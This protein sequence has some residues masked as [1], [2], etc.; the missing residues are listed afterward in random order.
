[1]NKSNN[2]IYISFEGLIWKIRLDEEECVLICEIRKE[3][4]RKVFFSGVDL[5]KKIR[6]WNYESGEDWWLSLF[7]SA[8]GKTVLHGL[9][10]YDNPRIKGFELLESKSGNLL[11]GEKEIIPLNLMKEGLFC[12]GPDDPGKYRLWDFKMLRL[13]AVNEGERFYET[14]PSSLINPAI[15]TKENEY[16]SGLSQYIEKVSGKK[17]VELIEYRE[18]SDKIIMAFYSREEEKLVNYL[19]VAQEDGKVLLQETMQR[20]LKGFASDTFFLWRDLL[21]FVKNRKELAIFEL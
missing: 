6:I 15:Y 3:S 12:S 14:M 4:E 11:A 16:F 7:D 17:A 20:D 1:M 5:R 13:R 8:Y 18:H 9:E 21:I 19:L 2:V 10:G